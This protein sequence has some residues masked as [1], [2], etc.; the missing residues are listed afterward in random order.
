[1]SLVGEVVDVDAP[2]RDVGV[3]AVSI[4]SRIAGGDHVIL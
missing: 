2:V 1:M 3:H 4:G